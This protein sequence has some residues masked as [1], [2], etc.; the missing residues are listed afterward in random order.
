VTRKKEINAI[1]K[2]IKSFPQ[3]KFTSLRTSADKEEEGH[4]SN[5][6]II[7]RLVVMTMTLS[8]NN[9]KEEAK[10]VVNAASPNLNNRREAAGI[11]EV[12]IETIL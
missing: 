12:A 1:T 2:R 7:S 3:M 4:K 9:L 10:E 11:N 6:I 8:T 5:P